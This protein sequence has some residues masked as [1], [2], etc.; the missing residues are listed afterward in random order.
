[1]TLQDKRILVTGAGGF[2]GSHL[3]EHLVR[4]GAVVRALVHY[5]AR[6]SSGWLDNS[7]LRDEIKLIAG[8]V[9]DPRTC[10]TAMDGCEIVFHLAALS[11]VPHSF[12][13]PTSFVRNNIDGTLQ[14]LET[15]RSIG[16]GRFIHA[17]SG[18]TFEPSAQRIDE[19]QRSVARS[20]YAATKI[21]CDALV[22]AWHHAFEVP[23]V[24]LKLF[25]VYGPRQSTRNVVPTIVAQ[26]LYSSEVSLGNLTSVRDFNYIDDVIRAFALAATTPEVAGQTFNISGANETSVEDLARKIGR[27]M[28]REVEIVQDPGMTRP[29]SGGADRLLGDSSTASRSLGWRPVVDL[30]VG[31]ARTIVWIR[32]HEAQILSPDRSVFQ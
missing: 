14:M 20:P 10:A 25:G 19:G 31:L 4:E 5:N 21:A 15:A 23:G 17:S 11:T 1:M 13:A 28:G 16:V 30:D 2:I 9:C 7:A 12:Q 6:G 29:G 18:Q 3:A 26:L 27:L 32:A 24:I 8:D 22:A